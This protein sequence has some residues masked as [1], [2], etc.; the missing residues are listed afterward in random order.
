M[1][2]RCRIRPL[3]SGALIALILLATP[4][5]AEDSA[6]AQA[7]FGLQLTTPGPSGASTHNQLTGPQPATVGIAD[8]AMSVPAAPI[9]VAGLAKGL[10]TVAVV[11]GGRWHV[12]RVAAD[13]RFS[14]QVDLSGAETGPLVI[15]VFGWDTEPDDHAYRIAVNLRVIVFVEG[16][17]P[18]AAAPPSPGHPAHGRSLVWSEPFETLSPAEWHLGPKP[19][20]QE[21]GAAVFAKTE[22]GGNYTTRGG[23]LRL[24]AQYRPGMEDPA[25]WK[26]QWVTGQISTGFPDGTA[27]AAFRTGYFEAR[28]MLPAGPGCWSS[29]W[30]LD[31][32]GIRA[33][34]T[35]GA[36]EIDAIEG[37]GHARQSYVATVHDWPPP[38]AQGK[39]YRKALRNIT[40]LPDLTLGFH[41]YGVDI[42][43]DEVIA[44]F[45][46]KEQFRAPLYRKERVSPF[47]MILTLAMSH[48]WPI[49]VP[50]SGTYDLWIDH[51]RVYR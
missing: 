27:P 24:R 34:G 31:R 49:A 44:Y 16:G 21:F 8:A 38:S 47:F 30:L 33:S 17:R 15:D 19:D 10:K 40:G 18:P 22:V 14:T 13:G 9:P 25:G 37:Y 5:R 32:H 39:G 45:D 50:P 43:E 26:R 1:M 48:D 4:A 36:V 7:P 29:F 6:L 20:G 41:D 35:N 23:F 51:V 11:V 12:T 2:P 3:R 46:G 42:T 28:M